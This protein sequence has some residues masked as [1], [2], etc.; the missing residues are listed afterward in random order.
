MRKAVELVRALVHAE[1]ATALD[2]AGLGRLKQFARCSTD[3]VGALF[4][5]LMDELCVADAR[6]RWL[7]L[8]VCAELWPR[9]AAFRHLLRSTE[10][11]MQ[12]RRQ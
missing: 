12:E 5:A 1:R 2:A 6:V 3:H 8:H 9:S 10:R 7:A 4:D 11:L